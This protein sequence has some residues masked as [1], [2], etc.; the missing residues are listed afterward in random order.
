MSETLIDALNNPACYPH[1]VDGIQVIES[2]LAW[3]VLTGDFAY[4]IKKP[5]DLYY[6]DAST[7]EARRILC[8]TEYRLNQRI[9]PEL[10]L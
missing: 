1:P 5:L 7:L 10:Y 3:I 8:E 9:F 4:K 2:D 6:L